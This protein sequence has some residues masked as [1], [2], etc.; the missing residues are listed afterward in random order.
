VGPLSGLE[1]HRVIGAVARGLL[2]G[3]F[4]VTGSEIELRSR[5]FDFFLDC[6]YIT[7]N[8]K[9]PHIGVVEDRFFFLVF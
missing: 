3:G 2:F 6:F 9:E 1:F 7:A 4:V 5:R 8:E